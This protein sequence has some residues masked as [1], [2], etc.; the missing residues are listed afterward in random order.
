MLVKNK[1]VLFFPVLFAVLA[2]IFSANTI[3]GTPV[4]AEQ[5]AWVEVEKV[6]MES[7]RE[8]RKK[9]MVARREAQHKER[10]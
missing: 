2:T 7:E 4:C 5:P 10:E 1:S 9:E 6:A 3:L 8:A